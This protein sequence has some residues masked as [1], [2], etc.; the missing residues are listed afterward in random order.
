MSESSTSKST[1]S[2]ARSD[3]DQAESTVDIVEDYLQ[4]MLD[5]AFN[6][7]VTK[8]LEPEL[9]A[10]K[11]NEPVSRTPLVEVRL[12]KNTEKEVDSTVPQTRA[13]VAASTFVTSTQEQNRV[14]PWEIEE[15][16]WILVSAGRLKLAFPLIGLDSVQAFDKKV[17]PF[18]SGLNW[19]PGLMREKNSNIRLVN[20]TSYLMHEPANFAES[21]NVL[22]LNGSS[23]GLLVDRIVSTKKI[24]KEQ[25]RRP[26]T[27]GRYSWRFGVLID[28]VY[29]L[30]DPLRLAEALEDSLRKSG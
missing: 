8:E 25:M 4:T 2:A 12:Q 3:A 15:L 6:V 13:V 1:T 18:S 23:W 19:L 9:V 24:T 20:I 27:P 5:T 30:I 28:P 7:S 17:T 11:S 22:V 29:T 26:A 16:E 14:P 21:D 10:A